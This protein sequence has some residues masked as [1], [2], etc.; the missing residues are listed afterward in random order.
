LS[1]AFFWFGLGPAPLAGQPQELER[2]TRTIVAGAFCTC[3]CGS[4]LP[5]DEPGACFGCSVGKSELSFVRSSLLAGQSAGEIMLALAEPV[6]VSVYGDYDDPGLAAVWRQS[7]RVADEFEQHRVVMRTPARSPIALFAV[8][9]V[10]CAREQDR[11]E[12]VRDAMI[13]Y[14]GPWQEPRLRAIARDHG[15]DEQGLDA[16]LPDVDVRGQVEKDTLHARRARITRFPAV[17][18]NGEAIRGGE[19]VLRAAVD[20]IVREG[21]I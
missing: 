10:E 12:P 15:V 3:G 8:K 4:S 6:T 7:K 5:G 16:C 19:A 17:V 21:S 11:F 14:E 9:V 2:R 1:V 18:V 13:E 20:A